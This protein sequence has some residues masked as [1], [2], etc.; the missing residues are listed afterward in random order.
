MTGTPRLA[1]VHDWLTTWG[2]AEQVLAAALE[3]YPEAPVCAL[4]YRPEVF[5][6]SVIGRHEIRTSFLDRMPFA[7]SRHRAYLP[8]MPLAVEQF[9]LREFDVIVSISH[10]VAHGVLP[11]PGQLHIIYRIY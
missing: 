6:N 7:R 11:Q 10:A 3:V 5:R 4:I 9:D 1:F 2:G 8:L